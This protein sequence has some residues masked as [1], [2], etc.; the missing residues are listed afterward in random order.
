MKQAVILAH[1]AGDSLNAAIAKAYVA[2]AREHGHE[3]VLRDLYRM[4]FDPRLKA[5]EIPGPSPPKFAA[6][7]LAER[8]ALA[9]VDVFVFVYPLWFNAP[10]AILKGYVDRV[11]GM[12]FG[13]KPDLGGSEP[14][15]HGRAL[16]SFTTSGAPDF[17]VQDTGALETLK[18]SFDAHLAGVTGLEVLDHV[19]FGG[20]V[21]GVSRQT[22][23]GVL[24]KVRETAAHLGL[25][26]S[27]AGAD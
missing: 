5:E 13:F 22:A 25:Q 3:V 7:V 21:A 17:W 12:G 8:A 16:L 9:D 18:H 15:L 1:P 11:F 6:D 27:P 10:P 4:G 14:A 19:H 26:H 23:D 20:M 24:T 2:A